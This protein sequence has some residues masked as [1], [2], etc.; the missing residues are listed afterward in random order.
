MLRIL[1]FSLIIC[2]CQTLLAQELITDSTTVLKAGIYKDFFEFKYNCPRHEFNHK[3]DSM[4]LKYSDKKG[5][6]FATNQQSLYFQL[7]NKKG[8]K[9]SFGF[10]DGKNIFI[11]VN[12]DKKGNP[13][14]SNVDHLGRYALMS[15]VTD[16][17]VNPIAVG[18]AGMIGVAAT[19]EPP[20]LI[21]KVV[22]LTTGNI[23]TLTESA[24]NQIVSDDSKILDYVIRDGN[25]NEKLEPYLLMYSNRHKKD[26]KNYDKIELIKSKK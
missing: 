11:K 3:V 7:K 24:L 2:C 25:I 19:Y 15:M 22:S 9:N 8:V 10:C 18:A 17:E 16:S 4:Y 1:S 20:R 21:L 5:L 13:I 26:V 12:Q 14:F 23:Y 6:A